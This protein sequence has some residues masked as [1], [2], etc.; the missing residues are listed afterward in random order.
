MDSS[1]RRLARVL[2][3]AVA[4]SLAALA[5]AIGV[6]RFLPRHTPAGQPPLATLTTGGSEL[7]DAFNGSTGAVRVLALLS[8]T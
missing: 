7:A 6:W 4:A 1:M 2:L 5:I 3:Y 8:P